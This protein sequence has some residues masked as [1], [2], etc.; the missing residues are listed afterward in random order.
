M[1]QSKNQM[2]VMFVVLFSAAFMFL[3]PFGLFKVKNTPRLQHIDTDVLEAY[4]PGLVQQGNNVNEQFFDLWKS[5]DIVLLGEFTLIKE[6]AEFVDQLLPQ[7]NAHGVTTVAVEFLAA[8]DQDA[9]N[10][11]LSASYFDEALARDLLVRRNAFFANLQYLNL[12]RTTWQNKLQILAIGAPIDHEWAS[13][14]SENPNAESYKKLYPQGLPD[15][16]MAALLEKQVLVAGKKALVFVPKDSA[17]IGFDEPNYF[18]QVSALGIGSPQRLGRLLKAKYAGKIAS[19]L[20]HDPWQNQGGKTPV[21][22]PASGI[23]DR[24]LLTSSS[25][26]RPGFPFAIHFPSNILGNWTVN[27][28]D[29]SRLRPWKLPSGALSTS[30]GLSSNAS[31]PV[32]RLKDFCDLYIVL[33]FIADMHAYEPIPELINDSNI[34]FALKQMP[35]EQRTS[36]NP[37]KLNSDMQERA[38]QLNLVLASFKL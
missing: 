6:Q 26:S 20:F 14:I 10:R 7:L 34:T 11:L 5:S 19:A 33:G 18:A 16:F 36:V 24:L 12:I 13:Q 8:D 25:E 15:E 21:V 37:G 35:K 28:S 29:Y 31:V 2:I 22:F 27:D 17:I 23:I 30:P 9:I 38:K 4:R 32:P 3:D 1:A